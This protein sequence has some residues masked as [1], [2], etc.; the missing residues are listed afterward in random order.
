MQTTRRRF[1]AASTAAAALAPH[2][3]MGQITQNNTT[4][5][6]GL[7][8]CGGRGTGAAT[9]ALKADSNVRLVAMADAFRDRLD[10]SLNRLR[11]NRDIVDKVDVADARKFVGFDAYQRLIDGGV[12]VV[13]LCTPPGFRP[14]HMH[15]AVEANKHIFAEKP[16]AVDAP[17]VRRVER[18]CA[19]ARRKNLSVVS[20]LCL[21]YSNNYK[22]MME[23]YPTL[24][25]AAVT[26]RIYSRRILAIYN[27]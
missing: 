14:L 7:V 19:E 10:A 26:F 20:G 16:I 2:I 18:I 9:Q 5:R 3:A 11:D 4:L 25:E 21:R 12:D 1:L 8:G 27:K 17:G 22:E 13:L 6:I 23:Y 15:A 24:I